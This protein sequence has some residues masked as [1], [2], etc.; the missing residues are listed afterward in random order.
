MRDLVAQTRITI[1]LARRRDR[2]ERGA[3]RAIAGRV[4]LDRKTQFIE[5]DQRRVEICLAMLRLTF[6]AW[7]MFGIGQIR[8]EHHRSARR[9]NA[10]DENLG[11]AGAYARRLIVG[12]VRAVACFLRI[13]LSPS[14]APRSAGRDPQIELAGAIERCIGAHRI[15]VGQ[16]VLHGGHTQRI[17]PGHRPFDRR[18]IVGV[19]ALGQ[20]LHGEIGGV[21]E[22]DAGRCLA[23]CVAHDHAAFRI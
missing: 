8:L 11:E 15:A 4:Q 5:F 12:P 14:R 22:Q 1:G 16:R 6:E 10:I 7:T 9:R 23:L 18:L 13:G 20:A 19:T 3:C 21:V 17:E 2:I